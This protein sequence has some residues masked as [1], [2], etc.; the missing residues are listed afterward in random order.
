[1]LQ[2]VMLVV[3]AWLVIDMQASS[4]VMIA[5]THTDDFILS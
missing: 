2:V 4:G 3:G 5:A 1:V